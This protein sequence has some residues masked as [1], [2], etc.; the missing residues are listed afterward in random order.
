[1]FTMTDEQGITVASKAAPAA[2]KGPTG[3]VGRGGKMDDV[4]ELDTEWMGE[5]EGGEEETVRGG[6]EEDGEK[7]EEVEED[8]VEEEE[9]EEEEEDK[10][11]VGRQKKMPKTGRRVPTE[12]NNSL[13]L[14][15]LNTNQHQSMPK[16]GRRVAS[17]VR[18][19]KKLEKQK[20][21]VLSRVSE[22]EASRLSMIIP[23]RSL[24]CL[25]RSLLSSLLRG[26]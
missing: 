23:Y 25:S 11:A 13:C 1:M 6:S 10:G 5:E 26:K 3:G 17:M 19:L 12:L 24:L 18:S 21:V 4:E 2:V 15:E 9:E 22:E 8:S 20:A 7:E 14:S 16:T